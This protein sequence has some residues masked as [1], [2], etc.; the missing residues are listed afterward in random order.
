M[1]QVILITGTSTGFGR[2]AAEALAQ[3]GHRVFATDA[4]HF[5]AQCWHCGGSAIA[6]EAGRLESGRFCKWTSPTMLP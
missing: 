2:S 1:S 4:R 6:G 3:R 5:R